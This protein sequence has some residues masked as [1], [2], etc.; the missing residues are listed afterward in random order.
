MSLEEEKRIIS[1]CKKDLSNF[2][3]LYEAFVNDIYRY[4]YMILGNK[5][6]A[7]DVTSQT[8]LNALE[9][10]KMF[11]WQEISIKNWFLK[12]AR[13]LSYEKFRKSKE[14]SFNEDLY[15]EVEDQTQ[16]EEVTVTEEFKKKLQEFIKE[17]DST[18]REIVTLRVW[19]EYK[20]REIA[21][22]VGM[23]KDSVKK[24]FY[25]GVEKLKKLAE[26]DRE[27]LKLKSVNVPLILAGVGTLMNLREFTINNVFKLQLA[28]KLSENISLLISSGTMGIVTKGA[29]VKGAKTA[30]VIGTKVKL[31]LATF[32]I[33]TV[34]GIGIGSYAILKNNDSKKEEPQQEQQQV[35]DSTD[36]E[37]EQISN[38]SQNN[39]DT[40]DAETQSNYTW[41]EDDYIK[42]QYPKGKSVTVESG[43]IVDSS[44]NTNFTGVKSIEIEDVIFLSLH[45]QG[46]VDKI[47]YDTDTPL[48]VSFIDDTNN[49]YSLDLIQK[50]WLQEL[51]NRLNVMGIPES[52]TQQG[53]IGLYLTRSGYFVEKGKGT[54]YSGTNPVQDLED[55]SFLG[56][57]GTLVGFN[58]EN[59]TTVSATIR[60][61][62]NTKKDFEFCHKAIDKILLTAQRKDNTNASNPYESWKTYEKSSYYLT[63]KIPPDWEAKEEV[64]SWDEVSHTMDMF[65]DVINF[66]DKSGK[67]TLTIYRSAYGVNST[68]W[69]KAKGENTTLV[70]KPFGKDKYFACSQ[71]SSELYYISSNKTICT[72]EVINF[73]I[74]TQVVDS[75][76]ALRVF[77]LIDIGSCQM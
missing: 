2:S 53:D 65:N 34:T 3:Q 62:L 75:N 20:F 51:S 58:A 12:I 33:V 13:N 27:S 4:S 40:N 50:P 46:G 29:A 25:R 18:S 32:G 28:D 42:F 74:D 35:E 16:T 52:N 73:E 39:T 45:Y 56:G 9:K 48:E 43:N 6:N 8:F 15:T 24:R 47:N 59:A 64:V 69:C 71:D 68:G 63:M 55:F 37:E 7:E 66:Y 60:C 22:L 26:K 11:T 57:T 54:S 49:T 30:G 36:Q 44:I 72:D 41:Y 23:K 77:D 17:L 1:K 19:E 67:V 21:E 70:E 10:F 76:T 31:A 5:H 38:G 14:V 61:T